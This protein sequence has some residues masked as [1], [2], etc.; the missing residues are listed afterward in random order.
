N[1]TSSIPANQ[2]LTAGAWVRTE[3]VNTNPT[4][5]AEKFQL[6]FEFFDAAGADLIGGPLVIDVPQG[7][8]STDGWVEIGNTALGTL[9]LPAAASSA[10]ITFRKGAQATG[11]VYLDDA[12][13]R[14]AGVFNPNVDVG[15]TWY[16]W[17]P[18]YEAGRADWPENQA[19]FMTTTEE[20]AH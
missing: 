10:R 2:E 5:D 15:D 8:A 20:A 18:D 13:I 17:W 14:G 1:W 4:G 11:A 19:F 6:V 3:G 16:Y 9:T 7:E 12:F